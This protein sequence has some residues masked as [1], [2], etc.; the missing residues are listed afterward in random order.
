[1]EIVKV[2]FASPIVWGCVSLAVIVIAVKTSHKFI[3]Q[4]LAFM[5]KLENFTEKSSADIQN[6]ITEKLSP[7]IYLHD[8]SDAVARRAAQII[9]EI[10]EI[11]NSADRLI[12][13]YGAASLVAMQKSN[14]HSEN[15]LNQ[16]A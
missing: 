3:E 8:G 13:F 11:E 9:S 7:R 6:I 15:D 14:D 12:T 1:M 10:A 5:T 16:T 2:I 4:A